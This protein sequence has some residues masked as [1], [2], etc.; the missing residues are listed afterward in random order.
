MWRRVD[1]GA[2]IE[3]LAGAGKVVLGLDV[4]RYLSETRFQEAAWSAYDR[5]GGDDV[6]AAR[7]AAL[8]ALARLDGADDLDDYEWVLVTW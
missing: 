1:V 6:E 5:T 2:A 3:A 7:S 4:R 8:A